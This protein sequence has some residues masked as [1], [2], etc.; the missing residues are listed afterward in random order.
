V[1]GETEDP[2][3]EINR[4]YVVCVCVEKVRRSRIRRGRRALSKSEEMQSVDG[5]ISDRL[6]NRGS[7]GTRT[8]NEYKCHFISSEPERLGRVGRCRSLSWIRR[9]LASADLSRK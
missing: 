8:S 7:R 1:E 2:G 3:T 6:L 5:W 4:G 9:G